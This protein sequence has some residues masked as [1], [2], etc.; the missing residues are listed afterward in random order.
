[1]SFGTGKIWMNGTLVDWADAKIHIASHVIHYGSGRLRG[2]ALLQD[3]E[4]LGLLPARR[5]HAP[6]ASIPR[7]IYRMDSPLDLQGWTTA[8]LDTIRANE[9]EG[10]LHPPAHLS[11]LRRARRQPAALPG[12]RRHPGLGMGRLPRAGGAREGRRR[13]RELVDPHGAEHVPG[14]WPRRRPTTPT[15]A[16]IKMEAMLDGYTEG[17]ALDVDGLRQ[18]GQRPEPLPRPRRRRSTR[19]R[20]TSSILPGITRDSIITL[21]HGARLRGARGDAAARGALPRRRGVLRRARRS[22]SRRS[23]RSTR[24]R[25]ARPARPDHRGHPAGV[26]RHHQRRGARHPRL[27]ARGSTWDAAQRPAGR[28]GGRARETGSGLLTSRLR[29]LP[30]RSGATRRLEPGGWSRVMHVNDLLKIAV[31]H[32]AS[33]LHLKVGSYP[34]DARRGDLVPATEEQ[35]PRSRGHRRH[36]RGR[37]V[38]GPAPEVQGQPGGR[39]RLQ[40]AGPRPLP[41]QRLP[42]AR[43]HRH[44]PARHPDAASGPS[45]SSVLPPVLKTH[46]RGGARPRARHRHDRQRQEHDAGGAD[47]PHQQHALRAH[48]DGRGSDRVPPPRQPVDHQPARGRRSTR[49]R[50][51]TRCAARCARIPTSSWSARCATSRRSRRRCSPPRPATS[52][53]RRCTRSTRPRRSTASSPSFRRTSRSRS[54]CS[55]RAC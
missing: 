26:L 36:G 55:S 2:R 16:L 18:R 35:A 44:G 5:P 33:D 47:R 49:G 6:A 48:D 21:A 54:A 9:L 34:D 11:R 23:G 50:S 52:C 53:S 8:I 30:P 40:R 37:D 13:L 14:A 51:R 32:G 29:G 38:H 19:R 10:L 1:M 39:P 20:S 42:A 25:S 3:A 28:G 22:R 43:H 12:R 27:A 31:E 4:G 24:S 15:P 7:K 41:L 45:T 46:R 17:I